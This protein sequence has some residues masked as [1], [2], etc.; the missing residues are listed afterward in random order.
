MGPAGYAEFFR[1]LK[2]ETE[3][4]GIV[5]DVRYNRGGHVS[6]LLLEKLSR[7]VGNWGVPRHGKPYTWPAHC[8]QGP[9]VCLT[10]ELAG[11]DGDIFSHGFKLRGLGP[12]IGMRTWGGV[13]GIWPRM[14]H[15][16]GSVTTQP[17]FAC[18]FVDAGYGIENHGADPDIVVDNTP[19]DFAAGHDAQLVRAVDVLKERMDG[20][21]MPRP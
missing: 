6:Q 13:V 7:T 21:S 14:R 10:N 8:P 11:S 18:W 12:L 4:Q 2:A 19:D 16:D 5:V 1:D 17:E 3:K 15:A 9:L 20:W